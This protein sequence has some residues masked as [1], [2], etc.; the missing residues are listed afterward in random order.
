MSE[1]DDPD[2]SRDRIEFI[3]DSIVA[4]SNPEEFAASFQYLSVG[5]SRIDSKFVDLIGY[6]FSQPFRA[7]VQRFGGRRCEPN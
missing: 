2:N 7:G 4:N 3:H 1:A 5:G 6:P